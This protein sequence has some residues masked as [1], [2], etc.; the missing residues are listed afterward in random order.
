MTL[1]IIDR[2]RQTEGVHYR[3]G[4]PRPRT[5]GRPG[6]GNY[7]YSGNNPAARRA[8]NNIDAVILHQTGR[9]F[10][11]VSIDRFNYVIA[12][13]AVMKDGTVLFLRDLSHALNS[14]GTDHRGIDVEIAGNYLRMADLRSRHR[15]NPR[16]MYFHEDPPAIQVR[17]ARE[18][19]SYLKHTYGAPKIFAHAQFAPKN[20][21]G[22]HLW[23]N[24][25]IW[26][27][28]ER[29]MINSGNGA[30]RI[31]PGWS[32]RDHCFIDY[33]ARDRQRQMAYGP[34]M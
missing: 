21:P 4:G 11:N 24:V 27:M 25:G 14:V 7:I 33:D 13:Y 20:C 10:D 8:T 3:R 2:R 26:A 28:R 32:D 29:H 16:T 1:R 9:G 17:A 6:V 31:P 23:Y 30:G 5:D 15:R 34:P 19:V 22:P 18:L 12:N